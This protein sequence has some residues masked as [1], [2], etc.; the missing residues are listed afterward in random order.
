MTDRSRSQRVV[1]IL[2]PGGLEHAGGIG[3]AMFYL[4]TQWSSDPAALPVQVID[5][6]GAGPLILSPL[7]LMLAVLRIVRLAATRRIALLH[8]NIASRGST[9]RKCVIVLLCVVL[10]IRF[11]MHLHGAK[12]D[13]FYA[14]LPRPAQTI[15]QWMFGSAARVI[16]L[17]MIWRRFAIDALGVTP[18]KID[19]ICNGVPD[20]IESPARHSGPVH[21]VFLGRLGAR[22][23]VPELVAA[24]SAG[25]L[26][27]RD[28][29]ATLAG[30]GDISR[31]KH[32]AEQGGIGERVSFPGWLGREA[33]AALLASGDIFVLPSHHEGLPVAV[34]EALAYGL[35][36][37]ATPVG[38][39]PEFLVD[40]ESVIFV[41]PAN[42]DQ[43]V[44]A[45]E[46]LLN[47]ADERRRLGAQARAV[48]RRHFDIAT[49]ARAVQ[50]SYASVYEPRTVVEDYEKPPVPVT[51]LEG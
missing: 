47:S 12:F 30:D 22:K 18:N 35:A 2:C 3:R 5:T 34:L 41:Q 49:T 10:R 46:H 39:L 14:N 27:G 33:T 29:K 48:F 25:R 4:I 44:D 45:L 23:G 37:I 26:V 21:I 17:G 38:S 24:L 32:E 31:F 6:R 15:V 51:H 1:C 28:W 40:R 11:V 13:Q 43:L 50:K 7:F 42:V 16:V 20:A 9:V 36:T 19:V 8:V